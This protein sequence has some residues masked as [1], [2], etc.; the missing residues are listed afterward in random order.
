MVIFVLFLGGSIRY[1]MNPIQKS[2]S[3]KL[4]TNIGNKSFDLNKTGMFGGAI[5]EEKE[6]SSSSNKGSRQILRKSRSNYKFNSED[7]Q[8][9]L[10]SN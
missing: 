9:N 10:S 4:S 8:D 3:S 2:K 5:L 1:S 7:L 6:G